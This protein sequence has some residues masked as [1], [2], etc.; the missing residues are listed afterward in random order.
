V[1]QIAQDAEDNLH[2]IADEILGPD[3]KYRMIVRLGKPSQE[4]LDVAKEEEVD[5]IFI[6]THGRTGLAKIVFGSVAQRVV[7]R[8]ECPVLTIRSCG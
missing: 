6:A 7:R 8:S 4:I 5:A 3:A 1:M 2:R